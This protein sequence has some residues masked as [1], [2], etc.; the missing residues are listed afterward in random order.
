MPG[1]EKIQAAIKLSTVYTVSQSGG[2]VP[3][4]AKES[5]KKKEKPP[6]YFAVLPEFDVQAV[7]KDHFASVKDGDTAL[8]KSLLESQRLTAHPH[9]TLVHEK[10]LSTE[11]PTYLSEK[12]LWDRC[13]HL[14]NVDSPPM[15]SMVLE[16]VIW[17]G[18]VMVIL[19]DDFR[20]GSSPE[21]DKEQKGAQFVSTLPYE[22]RSRLHVTVGTKESSIPPI[23]GKNLAERWRR[24]EK[25]KSV[26]ELD[27]GKVQVQ[28]RVKG[29]YA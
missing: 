21:E 1:E 5:S 4:Q 23:E 8:W 27:L 14:A 26:G 10:S 24:G 7:L 12:E 11:S 19:V 3:K 17:D 6:R 16:K 20:L 29:M 22:L 2:N 9:I 18:R 15:F 25:G 13:A 28:G